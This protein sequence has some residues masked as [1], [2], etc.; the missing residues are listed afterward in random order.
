MFRKTKSNISVAVPRTT[1]VSASA[2]PTQQLDVTLTRARAMPP[3]HI[4]Q[5]EI[6]WIIFRIIISFK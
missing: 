5:L 1:E 2:D 4:F 6:R 3:L